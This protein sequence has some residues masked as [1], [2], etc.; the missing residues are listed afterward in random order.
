MLPM[1][2]VNEVPGELVSLVEGAAAVW[3]ATCSREGVPQATRVMG[4][5]V[6]STRRSLTAFVPID[7]AGTTFDNLRE[8]GRLAIFFCCVTNYRAVQIKGDL[9]SMRPT[10]E[11][12]SEIQ[13]RYAHD[14]VEECVKVGIPRELNESLRHAPSMAVEMNVTAVF[15]QT[16]GPQAGAPWR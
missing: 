8:N 12:G 10:D 4:T 1:A 15:A 11:G 9:V 2:G 14:F 16:P 5:K 13:A 7:Q 6:G 3:L